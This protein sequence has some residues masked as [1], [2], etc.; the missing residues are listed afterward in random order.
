MATAGRTG[1]GAVDGTQTIGD[2]CAPAEPTKFSFDRV[3]LVASDTP[4]SQEALD[5]LCDG[6]EWA[7][8]EDAEAVVVLGG[9]GFMLHTLHRMIDE[10]RI[11][12]AYGINR[13]T[14]GFLMN[15]Y[16]KRAAILSRLARAKHM[17]IAPLRIT[18]TTQDGREHQMCAIN[19]LSLLRETRQ[20]AKIRVTVGSRVRIE[21][22]VGDGVLVA[23]PAGSTAYNFSA[24]GPILPLD[25]QML[26]LT[27][28]SPFRPRRWRGAILPD[29]MRITFTVLEP[30]KR[31]V[32]AVADQKELRDISEVTIEIARD[33]ELELLFDPGQSLEERIVSEQFNTA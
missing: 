5:I 4:R 13:G 33:T 6:R 31:P 23:T 28:I 24:N 27:P 11:V 29:R 25:S 18:A 12:P 3:A 2:F 21:E 19:E 22:L 30:D 9:D 1:T 26:A 20:T 16:D 8:I 14:V 7:A 32:A 15:R 10:K 17:A